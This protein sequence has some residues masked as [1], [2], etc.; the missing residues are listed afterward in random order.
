MD[1]YTPSWNIIYNLKQ[2]ST[3]EAYKLTVSVMTVVP[4]MF[5]YKFYTVRDENGPSRKSIVESY[6]N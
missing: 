6:L 3:L 5:A 1:C 4:K 2:C